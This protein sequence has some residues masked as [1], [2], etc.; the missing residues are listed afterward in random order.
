VSETSKRCRRLRRALRTA[1]AEVPSAYRLEPAH[2][3][4]IVALLART[5]IRAARRERDRLRA[6]R[7]RW[8]RADG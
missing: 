4:A 2:E 7:K 8:A 5:E 1:V 6:M 3:R